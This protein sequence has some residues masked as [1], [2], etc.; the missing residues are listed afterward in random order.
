MV[1]FIYE[2]SIPVQEEENT[3]HELKISGAAR[4]SNE[5]VPD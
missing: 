5:H 1:I 4:M 2:S 3:E